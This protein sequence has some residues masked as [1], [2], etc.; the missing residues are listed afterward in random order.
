MKNLQQKKSAVEHMKNFS[1]EQKIAAH[2]KNFQ[3]TAE[4]SRTHEEFVANYGTKILATR[5]SV[6]HVSDT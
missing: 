3:Q 1:R 2:V 6:Q 5:V 4:Y